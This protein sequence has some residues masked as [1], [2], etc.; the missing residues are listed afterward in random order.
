[1]INK[2]VKTEIY[3]LEQLIL[4]IVDHSKI[5]ASI[6]EVEPDLLEELQQISIALHYI[7]QTL[8]LKLGLPNVAG[9]G[10]STK[11]SLS[12]LRM[13]TKLPTN[14][15]SNKIISK[16]KESTTRKD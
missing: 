8:K 10:V 13:T 15:E 16:T 9:T 14:V 1:M 12:D 5:V 2:K 7:I 11:E 6:T 3:S 4:R